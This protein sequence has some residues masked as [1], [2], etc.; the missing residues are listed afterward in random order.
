MSA[1]SSSWVSEKKSHQ[2]VAQAN[3]FPLKA[4]AAHV[5]WKLQLNI[6]GEITSAGSSSWLLPLKAPADHLCRK[7]QLNIWEEITSAGSS[8]WLL[9][10]KAP[11]DHLSRKLQLNI[12]GE[13]TSDGSSSWLFPTK[14]PPEGLSCVLYSSVLYCRFTHLDTVCQL[15]LG[16][17]NTSPFYYTVI[18]K[19]MQ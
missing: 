16:R 19:M 6:W 3:C 15:I 2:Q 8:S 4:P 9:P 1:E 13:I 12:W 11:A 18:T 5:S 14:V 17:G 7:L 10:L